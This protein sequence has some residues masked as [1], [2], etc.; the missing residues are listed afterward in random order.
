M[1]YKI[2]VDTGGTF[3]DVVIADEGGI[4]V[5]EKAVTTHSRIFDGMRVALTQGAERLE[6]DLRTLLDRSAILIYGTT[7]A[8]NA[9]VTKRTAKTAFL[10]T[11]GFPDTLVFREGGKFRPTTILVLIT[12]SL[13]S[14]ADIHSKF[15]SERAQ[16]ARSG[17]LSTWMLRSR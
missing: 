17:F 6:L 4:R 12:L 3:T 14:H 16:K 13:M 7:W 2:S 15:Q 1:A 8:T 10:T 9:I 11:Q 5:L